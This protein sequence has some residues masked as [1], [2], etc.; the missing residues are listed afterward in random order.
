MDYLYS[1]ITRCPTRFRSTICSPSRL[2]IGLCL[3]VLSSLA[4]AQPPQAFD[5]HYA[6]YRNDS[7]VGDSSLSLSEKNHQWIWLMQTE[8]RGFYRWLTS[9]RPFEEARLTEVGN[10]LQ[11]QQLFKGDFPDKPAEQSTWFDTKNALIFHSDSSNKQQKQLS[12]QQPVFSYLNIHLLYTDMKQNGL[13][14][15]TVAFFKDGELLEATLTLEPQVTLQHGAKSYV[16]DKLSH[17]VQGSSKTLVYYYAGHDLA[18][19]KIEQL[20]NGESANS[21]WRTRLN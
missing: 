13:N 9:K 21:M 10:S 8:P 14:H 17:T 18:P 15:K 1:I 4:Y 19:L 5:A 12:F 2:L 6:V 11:L 20:K 16:A 7:H 3:G